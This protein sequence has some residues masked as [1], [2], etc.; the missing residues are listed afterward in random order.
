MAETAVTTPPEEEMPP[1][2]G[3][4]PEGAPPDAQ[5]QAAGLRPILIK[6]RFAIDPRTPLPDLDSP[7]AKA[8]MA[9]D[10]RDIDRPV[11][12]LICNPGLPTRMGAMT[13]LRGSGIKALVGILEWDVD[14]WPLIRQRTMILILE[15][16]LGGRVLQKGQFRISEYDLPRKV[17]EP[18]AG[19]LQEMA[20]I[21][22]PHRAIRRDNLFFMDAGRQ[23]IA[24]GECYS[25][26]PGYDQPVVY[27][28]SERAMAPPAGRGVGNSRDDTYAFA[29]TIVGLVLDK[30]PGSHLEVQQLLAQKLDLGSYAAI[31]GNENLPLSL[32]E[33][34]RGMLGDDPQQRWGPEEIE[35]WLSG[36]KMSPQQKRAGKRGQTPFTFMGRQYQS[37]R[38]LADAFSRHIPEGAK[39]MRDDAFDTW[40]RRSVEDVN[41]A[42]AIKNVLDVARAQTGTFAGSDEMTVTR[43][44][45]LMD[46]LG[47]IRFKGFS[48]MMD[49][50][51]PAFAMD[52]LRTGNPQIPAEIIAKDIPDL[53]FQSQQ[54]YAPEASIHQK[55]FSQ[56]KI[57]LNNKD[58]G[59]GLERCLYESNPS[60]PC[61][62]NLLLQEYVLET[63]HLLPALDRAANT[64][65]LKSKPLDRHIAAFIT[66]R[67]K[68]DINPHLKALASENPDT[69]TIGM[70]SLLAFIQWKL[71]VEPVYG[72]AS[73]V[74]GHLGPAINAYHSRSTRK[75]IEREIP[76]L[77]RRGSL[78]ELFDL[79]DNADRRREDIEGFED[80]V[81]EFA[82]A[83]LEIQDIEGR[84][85]E[86]LTKAERT[87]QQAAAM[88][89][90]LITMCIVMILFMV[91]VF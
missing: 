76:R 91:K 68:E 9:E 66:S 1:P 44:V 20:S 22:V 51:G 54:S 90:I 36:R 11:F 71:R 18:L 17:I 72:L 27:E 48:F 78:P 16:P 82:G 63:E 46:P 13:S 59:F 86:Q 42:N 30:E 4:A 61:Q 2:D 62:S 87:G 73:W 37:V 80:A 41:L 64:Q 14:Y 60:L 3:A 85:A 12:A 56:L 6:D 50:F 8:F 53:W 10:R 40:L 70:L 5:Q 81:A 32:L 28:P 75:E 89:S 67:F 7:S 33:P 79:M 84:G 43:V 38:Q 25:S 39:A 34:L 21:G 52:L 45:I 24:F 65:D 77:V 29:V 88:G 47:P 57:V 19:A 35:L 55:N 83:E 58:P 26:P 23:Q 49:G 69:Q 31:T 74:G 15:R